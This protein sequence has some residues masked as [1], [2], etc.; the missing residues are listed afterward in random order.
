MILITRPLRDYLLFMIFIFVSVFFVGLWEIIR[1]DFLYQIVEE[2]LINTEK[3]PEHILDDYYDFRNDFVFTNSPMIDI[4]NYT[5]LVVVFFMFYR[6]FQRGAHTPVMS[7][8]SLF[9]YWTFTL[10][11]G[12]YISYF[13]ITNIYNILINQ[14]IQILFAEILNSLYV[15]NMVWEWNI[16]LF[17]VLILFQYFGY[18]K[19]YFLTT[20]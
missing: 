6:A 19:R 9:S 8:G 1:E 4:L 16:G 11:I 15:F 10:I 3:T 7:L 17:V 20:S 18:V 13:I 5:S 2:N 14:I 12:I